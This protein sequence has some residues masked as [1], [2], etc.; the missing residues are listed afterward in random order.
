MKT[1]TS[2]AEIFGDVIDGELEHNDS[3]LFDLK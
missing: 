3:M 2:D 1:M